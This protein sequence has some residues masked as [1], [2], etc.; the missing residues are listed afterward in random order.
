MSSTN[1]GAARPEADYYPTPQWAITAILREIDWPQITSVLEPAKGDGRILNSVR[2]QQPRAAL[3]WAEISEGRDYLD[4]RYAPSHDARF[5]LI[6]TNPPFSQA[7]EF[8]TKALD[9]GH[10]VAMLLRLGF[11]GSQ[12]RLPWW[13]QHP[14][15][16][17]FVL[18]K[19]PSFTGKGTDSADYAWFAWGS[20][21]IRPPGI[22]VV[23]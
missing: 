15:Q 16:R 4:R 22:Y 10:N 14:V 9:E 20:D 1:R 8:A 3:D 23:I 18:A 17:L 19:R 7:L 2:I 11:L 13:Q 5:D 6:L 21:F 12:K